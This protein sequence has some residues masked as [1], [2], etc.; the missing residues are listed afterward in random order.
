V[1]K[2][3]VA[4]MDVDIDHGEHYGVVHVWPDSTHPGLGEQKVHIV[5]DVDKDRFLAEFTKAAQSERAY[6][7]Q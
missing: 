2:E 7:P 5:L 1:T 4:Y 3:V 6:T